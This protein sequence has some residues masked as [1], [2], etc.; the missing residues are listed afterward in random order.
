MFAVIN[1]A[2]Q[3]NQLFRLRLSPDSYRLGICQIDDVFSSVQR[4]FVVAHLAD[5]CGKKQSEYIA[6]ISIQYAIPLLF[7]ETS[8]VLRFSELIIQFEPL[9]Q[10]FPDFRGTGYSIERNGLEE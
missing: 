4:R 9:D 5:S 3:H 1:F 7:T 10:Q 6:R 8:F 2:V